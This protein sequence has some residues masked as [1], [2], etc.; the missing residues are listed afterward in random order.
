MSLLINITALERRDKR[1]EGKT[2]VALFRN[3]VHGEKNVSLVTGHM[4]MSHST[5]ILV[6]G[7]QQ[8]VSA[9]FYST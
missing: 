2:V 5:M 7:I 1:E 9:N 3:K 6:Q 8:S 4:V